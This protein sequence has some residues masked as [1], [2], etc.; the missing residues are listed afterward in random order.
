MANKIKGEFDV[1]AGDKT[2]KGRFGMNALVEIE[3]RSGKSVEELFASIEKTKSMKDA[4]M[5][6]GAA[7][8][9]YHPEL[10]DAD[11]G[12]IIDQAGIETLSSIMADG[13]RAAFP[14]AAKGEAKAGATANPTSHAAASG[15]GRD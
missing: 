11:V 5:I 7:L 4:R 10:T 3:E 2:Y 9:T 13:I 1:P 6:V 15:T 8:R 12:T 14:E